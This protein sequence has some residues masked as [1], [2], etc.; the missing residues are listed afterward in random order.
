M[1]FSFPAK[2]PYA[3]RARLLSCL[4]AGGLLYERDGVVAVDAAGRIAYAGPAEEYS[5]AEAPVDI[6]PL[7]VMPG[8][9]DVHGHLPQFPLTGLSGG[10]TLIPW[11]SKLMAPTE[12]GFSGQAAAPLAEH[13]FSLFAAAGTTTAVLYGSV[14]A[15]ATDASFSVAARHG[16]RVVL[17][18][19][20]M[21]RMRYDDAPEAG[22]TRRRLDES[23]ALCRA[24]HG[25][26][27]GRLSYA[28]TPRFA[29]SCSREMMSESARLARQYD[30]Y[31]QT[32][33]SEDPEEMRMIQEQFPEAQDYLDVYDRAG[34]LGPRAIFAHAVHLSERE[35]DR[36]V[37]TGSTV[38]HCPSNVFGGGGI[39]DTGRY[40]RRGVTL[41]LASDVGGCT[42]I[43][44]FKAMEIG[45]ITQRARLRLLP[46][47]DVVS[48]FADWLELATLGSA[49]VLG[50]AD[51]IGSLEAGKEADLIA[52]D[53]RDALLPGS[54]EFE[55]T[56]RE[57][58][59]LTI[60]RYRPGMVKSA[61]VR[62]RQVEG[63]GAL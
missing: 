18:Q 39:L 44:L 22:I 59:L 15:E 8:L 54:R 17:G 56:E 62:G 11:L 1:S 13:Y 4:A 60:F 61:W 9:I 35:I 6:R 55:E 45:W 33:L 38:A 40:R 3:L 49:R 2:G 5:G 23:E 42:D 21:D 29:L 36:L 16:L 41:G 52:V 47:S 28:F 12:R 24:W 31:W 53:P 19:C 32:H 37:E 20:L 34:G 26:D 58:L 25:H 30:A 63:P 50:L 43:S 7:A 14:D 57:L 46:E 51:R 48:E 27:G 10:L